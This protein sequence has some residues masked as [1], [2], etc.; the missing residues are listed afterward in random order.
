MIYQVILESLRSTVGG[1]QWQLIVQEKPVSDELVVGVRRIE[2]RARQHLTLRNGFVLLDPRDLG[3]PPWNRPVVGLWRSQA[4][5]VV[6]ALSSRSHDLNTYGYTTV[7]LFRLSKGHWIRI[8]QPKAID[9]SHR[10][11]FQIVKT[12]L[13]VW[14]FDPAF[15]HVSPA[16]YQVRLISFRGK[17]LTELWF[18]TTS[19]RYLPHVHGQIWPPPDVVAALDDPLREFGYKWKW[20]GERISVRSSLKERGS[21]E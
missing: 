10:G 5:P 15:G 4:G 2:A 9:F 21:F 17:C 13:L 19:R 14:D 18:R 3:T 6:W 8:E 16:H 7:E 11:G 1:K 20:W 12:G